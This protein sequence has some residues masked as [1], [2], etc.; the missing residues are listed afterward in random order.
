MYFFSKKRKYIA[1]TFSDS[2]KRGNYIGTVRI[3]HLKRK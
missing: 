3:E 2:A 1:E